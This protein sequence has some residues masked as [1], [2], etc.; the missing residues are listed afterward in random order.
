MR[1]LTVPFIIFFLLFGCSKE[2]KELQLEKLIGISTNSTLFH[3]YI[4]KL[5]KSRNDSINVFNLKQV[6]AF[7]D[8]LDPQSMGGPWFHVCFNRGITFEVTDSDT[9]VGV[10]IEKVGTGRHQKFKCNLPY[11][12]KP[13]D[14]RKDIEVKLGYPSLL[15]PCPDGQ[16]TFTPFDYLQPLC[17]WWIDENVSIKIEYEF[18]G[19]DKEENKMNSIILH[20]SVKM[21]L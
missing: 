6:T 3:S 5:Q 2:E 10:M 11:N 7:G 13:N 4:D 21:N 9:I 17:S 8:E 18:S 12:L 19:E 16:Y 20:K 15:G 1:R 14:T